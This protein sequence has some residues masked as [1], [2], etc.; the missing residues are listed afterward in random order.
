MERI[1]DRLVSWASLLDDQTR[2]QAITSAEIEFIYPHIALMP[3]AHLG[4]GATVGSVIPTLG[5]VMPAAVG[6]DI[7]C[8]MTAVQT[9]FKFTDLPTNLTKLREEIERSIPVS[10]GRYNRKILPSA[11]PRVDELEELAL[12]KD[13]DPD[14]FDQNWRMQ[15]GT[16][17]GGNHF[18]EVCLD[19]NDNVWTFLHS[20]S[21]GIGNRIAQH[22][23]DTAKSLRHQAGDQLPHPDLAWLTQGTEEFDRYIAQLRWAQHFAL[24]NREEMME[25][26]NNQL[27]RW[28]GEPVQSVQY[29]NSHHNFTE[30]EE[31]FGKQVW[32]TRKGAIR[33]RES[34][35]A[36][37]PGSMGAASYIVEGLGNRDA[38]NSAPHGAGRQYSR[39]AAR[40]NFTHQDL[41]DAMV[42]IEYRDTAKF[43]DE[44]P[45]AYKPID[46]VMHDSRQLVTIRHTL[47]QIVNVKG[48]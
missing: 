20:G 13:F 10:A 6:V 39:R 18:I 21:R 5:A 4:Y 44:I 22:H 40:R 12:I 24:L 36:A 7:G 41:R 19:E 15:L 23:I 14:S 28:A 47:R 1:N 42:G 31:H 30:Q 11:A 17:G 34:D 38:L 43:I 46:Q 27:G 25:R 32:V 2:Q 26:L 45:Q 3:D 8:G 48:E 35:M 37:I 33:A 9:Q 16:L 29:I